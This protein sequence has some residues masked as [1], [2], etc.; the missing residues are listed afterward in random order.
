METASQPGAPVASPTPDP[1]DLE[2]SAVALYVEQGH[3]LQEVSAELGIA[4]KRVT[5]ILGRRGVQLRRRGPRVR[6]DKLAEIAVRRTQILELY[7]QGLPGPEIARRVGVSYSV[8]YT[9]LEAVG[10]PRRR[11]GPPSLYPPVPDLSCLWCGA[12]VKAKPSRV[13]RGYGR[14]CCRSHSYLHRWHVTGNGIAAALLN[15]LPAERRQHF[16]C[17]WGGRKPPGP[18]ARPRG[19]PANPSPPEALSMLETLAALGYGIATIT[20]QT[21]LSERVVRRQ[22]KRIRELPPTNGDRVPTAGP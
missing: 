12:N 7:T 2:A 13:A 6:A 22:L 1:I 14:F 3:T 4:A 5:T 10:K 15:N 19:R 20:K 17:S 9:D 11:S 21:H 18:G 16:K 8:V